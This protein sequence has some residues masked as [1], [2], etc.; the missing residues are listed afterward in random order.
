VLVGAITDPAKPQSR[1]TEQELARAVVRDAARRY[2]CRARCRAPVCIES[3]RPGRHL[4]RPPFHPLRQSRVAFGAI[5]AQSLS[6]STGTCRQACEPSGPARRQQLAAWLV[7]RRLLFQTDL[8]REIEWLVGTSCWR[9]GARQ[10]NRVSSRDALGEA[11][12]ADPSDGSI[13][14]RDHYVAR[15]IDLLDLVVSAWRLSRG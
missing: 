4:H 9:L 8:A 12:L 11:V 10:R 7:D 1:T 3:S 14:L 15:L 6:D 13:T 2:A 5:T